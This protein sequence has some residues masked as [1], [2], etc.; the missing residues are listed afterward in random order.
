MKLSIASD[1]AGFEQKELLRAYLE[2]AGHEVIDRGPNSDDRV[3]YPDYAVPVA[4]D[5]ADGTVERGVLVCGTGIGMAL[6][7]DKV[8]GVRAAN[9]ITPQFAALCR[10]H[11]DAN[12][13]TL[14][15][16]FVDVDTNKEILD[17]FLTTEFGGGRHAGR[18]EKIMALDAR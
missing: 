17:V 5:V 12:V 6:A 1:H 4:N 9:I 14:S 18:V 10:E 11:N 8:A 13:I 15:G 2:S 7:A 3:D 16:R